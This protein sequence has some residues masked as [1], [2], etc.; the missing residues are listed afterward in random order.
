MLALMLVASRHD[1]E[2]E[3]PVR[4]KEFLFG[5]NTVLLCYCDIVGT[6]ENYKRMSQ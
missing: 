4:R 1:L 2:A 3:T 5:I 6:R